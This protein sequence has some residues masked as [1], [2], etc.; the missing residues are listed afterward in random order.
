[1]KNLS[2]LISAT[3][4]SLLLAACGGFETSTQSK[5]DVSHATNLSDT[6]TNTVNNSEV[7]IAVNGTPVATF[8]EFTINT[9][10]DY[11]G[12]LT[13]KDPD[14]DQLSYQVV[15]RPKHGEIKIDK[16]GYFTY[17]PDAGYEGVDSFVYRAEDGLSACP[18][19]PVLVEVKKQAIVIPT[20]PSQLHL[21]A[22]STCKIKLS[23]QDNSDNETGFDIYQDGRLVSVVKEN[24]TTTNICGG[25]HPATEYRMAVVAKNSTGASLPVI[26]YVT[27][28]D[29]SF[30]PKAPSNLRAVAVDK[31]RVRLAWQDNAWSES[32]Y[33]VYVNGRWYKSVKAD[34]ESTVVTG[35]SAGSDY[36]FFVV[37]KNKI[38]GRNSNSIDV[39]TQAEPIV[40]TTP[41]VL[42]LLGDKSSQ[43]TVGD[44]YV[45]AGAK[46]VDDNDG[47]ISWDIKIVS[48]VDTSVAGSYLV[49]YTLS[50]SAG[51]EVS[52]TRTVIVKPLAV[53]LAPTV[54]IVGGDIALQVGDT[55]IEQGASVVDP[56]DGALEVKITS[57][58]DTSK[59]G[60]YQVTYSAIDSAGHT[61]SKTRVVRVSEPVFVNT[62]PVAV[63][64]ALTT[65]AGVDVNVTLH[66]NDAD[67]D[68]L[69]YTITKAP[70]HGGLSGDAPSL[71]Y[72]P[73]E[74]FSGNDSFSFVANDTE[75]DSNEA[76][77]TITVKP[78][79]TPPV[80][81][82]EFG[83]IKQLIHDA[84]LGK[85][86]D[87]TF[88]TVGD[89]TRADDAYY[90]GGELFDAL[91]ERLQ[92]YHVDAY[93]QAKAG[94]TMRKWNNFDGNST[95]NE[96]TW[97][98]TVALIPG[99]GNSTI[100]SISLGINDARYYG[101]GGEKERIKFHLS[102]AQGAMDKILAQKPNTHFLLVMPHKF[103]G[104]DT[105]TAAV[106]A[107]YE[108]MAQER[109]IPL[110]HTMDAAFFDTTD[111]SLYRA[112]DAAEYGDDIRIHLSSKGQKLIS[113]LI[114][115]TILP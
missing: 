55:Y 2:L 73:D 34:A 100:V 44:V 47:D 89:S 6:S 114:L 111:L 95:L 71:T 85:V 3:S 63:S 7:K 10:T 40:D 42:T 12:Q 8:K 9:D 19:Q 110:I 24:T 16:N 115:E 26:G 29:I 96:P 70:L 39:K 98:D 58:V 32:A 23:W 97:E 43:L 17:I 49:T 25:M 82:G 35:L 52:A 79:E 1:M 99:D 92:A 38:G 102:G 36:T 88:I 11:H 109:G 4:L 69:T 5:G 112:A 64:S 28:K 45:E 72:T 77:I 66:A 18:N 106:K 53:D 31:T 84:Q 90:G 101:E 107:A 60:E 74:G 61:V 57:T 15:S 21:E 113:D 78:I 13:A 46:A 67:A 54:T 22:L 30:S 48:T 86:T 33:D 104:I 41:P 68:P 76:T 62:K 65:D 75:E 105:K 20:A 80:Y 91:K 14:H 27:T 83:A 37:A 50:D 93:L 108:E 59:A 94:H 56:E 87:A 81:Q 103:V 51:N